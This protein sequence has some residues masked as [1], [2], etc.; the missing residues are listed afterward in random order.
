MTTSKRFD[1]MFEKLAARHEGA[2][3]PFA[4]VCHP[5]EELSYEILKTMIDNG[6]DGLELGI[7]FSDPCADGL[8]IQH[9][10]RRALN[11]GST[12]DRCFTVI[13]RLR[14]TFPE[15]PISLLVYANLVVARGIDRFYADAAAAGVDAILVPDVP[16]NMQEG[17]HDFRGP[18]LKHGINP[19]LIAPPN[20][21]DATLAEI[22]S[23]CEG[24][25]YVLS[26][27]G[28]TGTENEF[29]RHPDEFRKLKE[30]KAPHT[31]LGFGI[32]TPEHVKEALKIGADG[33]IV[34]S[35][36]VRIIEENVANPEKMLSL[37]A[38][39]VKSYK[40]ATRPD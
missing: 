26:R 6:A 8:I 24:Y 13:K 31:L 21:S 34:G 15:L 17:V 4:T 32:S 20:A 12:T 7:P 3:V 25:T 1:S 16:V 36:L 9:A 19:V 5:T 37:I 38:A 35:A 39:K 2:F 27:F 23:Q 40:D 11:N 10:N 28:I 22:A 14:D 18:A 29:G 30:L 33:A